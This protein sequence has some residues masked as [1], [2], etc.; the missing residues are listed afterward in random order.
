V[1]TRRRGA[2]AARLRPGPHRVTVGKLH[3]RASA[4]QTKTLVIPIT[5][6]RKHILSRRGKLPIRLSLVF[7]PDADRGCPRLRSRSALA[8]R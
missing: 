6:R 8:D 3:D 1:T 2:A 7:P 5:S 4:A